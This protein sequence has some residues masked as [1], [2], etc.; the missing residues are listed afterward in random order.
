MLKI[1]RSDKSRIVF[2]GNLTQVLPE[3]AADSLERQTVL[4]RTLASDPCGVRLHYRLKT[5]LDADTGVYM[6]AVNILCTA[7]EKSEAEL[8]ALREG[9][10]RLIYIT[11]KNHYSLQYSYEK[12]M[13]NPDGSAFPPDLKGA[14]KY[15][16]EIFPEEATGGPRGTNRFTGY[17]QWPF[18]FDL[19]RVLDH[20]V[21]LELR[22]RSAKG[23]T[24]VA[25]PAKAVPARKLRPVI[26]PKDDK[27]AADF[28][29]ALAEAEDAA[30]EE[31]YFSLLLAADSE[32]PASVIRSVGAVFAG[33][34]GFS[35]G[36]AG[37]ENAS[38]TEMPMSVERA[39]R[40]F[41]APIGKIYAAGTVKYMPLD[42]RID[43]IACASPREFGVSLGKTKFRTMQGDREIDVKS[44]G[45]D[46]LRHTY[47]LGKTGS[48]K[49]NLL[50]RMVEQD[51]RFSDHGLTVIDPHG[52]LADYAVRCVPA[53]KA[54]AVVFLDLSRTDFLPV[55]NPLDID[56]NDSL[57]ADRVIQEITQILQKRTY[58]EF[59]GPRFQ[60]YTRLL[61]KTMLDPG[62][63]YPASLADVSKL[64]TDEAF[65]RDKVLPH[66]KDNSICARWNYEQ[67]LTNTRDYGETIIWV[68]SKFD[69]IARNNVL[70]AVLG[71]AKSSV[72]T[73]DI[74]KNGRILIVKIPESVLGRE[75]ADLIGSIIV[76][77]LK[78][79]MFRRRL[80]EDA[81]ESDLHFVY[82][83]EFQNFA[84]TEFSSLVAEARKF[85][86]GFIL[87]NQNIRQIR[88]FDGNTGNFDGSLLEAI[89]GNVGNIVSFGVGHPDAAELSRR[90]DID[91]SRLLRIGKYEALARILV[92]GNES[93]K[94]A[95]YAR[96][97]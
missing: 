42:L 56:R 76:M 43:D 30:A 53:E 12:P 37:A 78:N 87:A 83:D 70:R 16:Y 60:E 41:H 58:H 67:K 63:P 11:F 47:I 90:F 57:V 21:A 94:T 82:I 52:D 93:V 80:K 74:V 10:G 13:R 85:G 92:D 73:E 26:L 20:P 35:F 8:R 96:S 39:L 19:L 77:Q 31:L 22:C 18:L 14:C 68:L 34:E 81:S 44:A 5:V 95:K 71:G 7:Y 97:G 64:M 29:N 27:E 1:M 55:L 50:K 38:R 28:L 23:S 40:L 2:F 88:K 36:P 45:T 72:D 54:D 66:L 75:T 32:I 4:L 33:E 79:A 51:I 17:V 91:A 25:S 86:M 24:A 6:P 49:T 15:A 62:Y 65:R 3:S 46:R 89:W 59:T 69:D 9:I 48:G 61:L 84:T